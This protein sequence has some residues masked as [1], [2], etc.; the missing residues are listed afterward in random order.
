MILRFPEAW[1][2]YNLDYIRAYLSD[3]PT[4]SKHRY[5]GYSISNWVITEDR[6]DVF[7]WHQFLSTHEVKMC[8][9]NSNV[10]QKVNAV[11]EPEPTENVDNTNCFV[12]G[13]EV[14]V[15]DDEENWISA[16]FVCEIKEGNYKYLIRHSDPD[17][18]QRYLDWENRVF[19]MYKFCVHKQKEVIINGEKYFLVKS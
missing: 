18:L 17:N 4:N 13:Q 9:E 15:S 14:L 5:I 12:E 3:E 8:M 11:Q 16:I 7:F 19:D 2:T 6:I 1:Y 10:Q